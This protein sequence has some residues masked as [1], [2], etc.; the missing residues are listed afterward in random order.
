MK[1]TNFS[2]NLSLRYN[3]KFFLIWLNKFSLNYLKGP[4]I[5]HGIKKKIPIFEKILFLE[6]TNFR[7]WLSYVTPRVP[8]GSFEKLYKQ[9]KPLIFLQ[10]KL[11][12]LRNK[13][14]CVCTHKT[15]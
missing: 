15:V 10:L 7:I 9:T 12:C 4:D 14:D 3:R 2:K 1:F 13:Q 8:I 5:A 6:N 11:S